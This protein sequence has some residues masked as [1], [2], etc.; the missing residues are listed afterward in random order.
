[1]QTY[2]PYEALIIAEQRGSYCSLESSDE[3]PLD[4]RIKH[5]ATVPQW[6]MALATMHHDMISRH[7][8]SSSI[9]NIYPPPPSASVPYL[10]I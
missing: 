6:P 2:S 8:K 3:V 7:I 5:A 1:M 9:S 4:A 10:L